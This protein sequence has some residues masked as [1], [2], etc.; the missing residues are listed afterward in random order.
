[1]CVDVR[2]RITAYFK[3]NYHQDY[4]EDGST[5]CIFDECMMVN[6]FQLIQFDSHSQLREQTH[7]LYCFSSSSPVRSF[8]LA[9]RMSQ[10][11]SELS[12]KF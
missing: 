8:F 6:S 5:I 3:L 2:E 12:W 9:F 11:C 10:I 4:S 1:M 7:F